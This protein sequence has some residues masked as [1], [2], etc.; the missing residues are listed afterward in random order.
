MLI[1]LCDMSPSS[2]EEVSVPGL[3]INNKA[4]TLKLLDAP[5][6]YV[7]RIISFPTNFLPSSEEEVIPFML[8]FLS[9]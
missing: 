2:V 8:P 4:M 3:L 7:C 5:A 9:K 1:S 6:G